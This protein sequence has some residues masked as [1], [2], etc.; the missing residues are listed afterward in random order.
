L[1]GLS[2][3]TIRSNWRS[4]YQRLERVLPGGG[5]NGRNGAGGTRGQE[6]RRI[7]IE[8]LRQN[9]HELR[10]TLSQADRR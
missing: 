10:P 2:S 3:E 6:K 7:A 9:M 4:I 5:M 8:Y 1:L